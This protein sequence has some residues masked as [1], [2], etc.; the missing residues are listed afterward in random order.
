MP[1]PKLYPT[2]TK[3]ILSPSHNMP[4]SAPH[5]L[6]LPFSYSFSVYYTFLNLNFPFMFLFSYLLYIYYN[7]SVFL[8]LLPKLFT[9]KWHWP[10][11]S[12]NNP[13]ADSYRYRL[14]EKISVRYSKQQSSTITCRDGLLDMST[15]CPKYMY[16]N[17]PL[18]SCFLLEN[19]KPLF[20]REK[21]PSIIGFHNKTSIV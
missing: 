13:C 16:I 7:F 10:I 2:S 18:N 20:H 11:F 5:A 17:L 6:F 19:Y 8:F 14:V 4:I 9:P 15:I 1:V 12:I 21:K 3:K